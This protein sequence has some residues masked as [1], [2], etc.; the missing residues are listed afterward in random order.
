[1]SEAAARQNGFGALR[2][3]FASLVILSHSP[4][5]IDGDMSREPIMR[6]FGT[7]N[8]GS[9]A[10]DGFFLI[11]GYLI[12]AS[13]VSDPPTYF[14]KRILR[15]YPG[16]IVCYLLCIFLVA[17]LGG[18]HLSDLSPR[19][20]AM[21]LARML[22]LKSPEV[23]G[24]FTGLPYPT[25]DGSMW[26]IIYEARCYVLAA[27]IGLLGFYRRRSLLLA[28]TA[29][30]LAANFLFL[31]PVGQ[32]IL[33]VTRPLWGALGEPVQ[34]VGLTSIFLCGAAFRV[35]R[36]DYRGW[37]AALCVAAMVAALFV[38]VL[39]EV[40]VGVA[41]GYAL[42][43]TA[44]KVKWRPLLTINAKDD[45]S[46]GVYLY[47]WPVGELIL[48]FWRAVPLPV[49]ILATFA[50]SVACGAVSWWL[51]E[52]RALSLK[53]RFWTAKRAQPAAPG[54]ELAPP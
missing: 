3:L 54:G 18:A 47:A 49:L 38:P 30:T 2:L 1:M 8:L 28:L 25:L 36:L 7:T 12:S 27:L 17:T 37:I 44:F 52:K 11:S 31:L 16:Y 13:F 33:H 9:L 32:S 20:W 19:R 22:A 42:F 50:G 45:I 14:W 46:Y 23:D 24:A 10:V 48:W 39:G 5:M 4:Q 15:I 26:T 51:V 21:T 34:A 6:V 53:A 41:G 35:L 40:V 43:W 29:A